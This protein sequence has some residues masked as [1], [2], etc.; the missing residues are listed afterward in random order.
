MGTTATSF[1]TR[2]SEQVYNPTMALCFLDHLQRYGETPRQLL[3]PNLAADQDKL[4]FV[5]RIV[6]G[7]QTVLDVIRSDT[8]LEINDL[9]SRFTLSKLM[10][11][12]E[13]DENV[14][15]SYLYY[16]GLLTLSG[17]TETRDLRLVPPN[18][19]VRKLFFERLVTREVVG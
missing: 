19:V 6:A 13:G 5:A 18:L 4:R 7:Q 10:D 11:L 3:D 16:I 12:L 15:V 2:A 17:E 8:P 9:T 14:V 1:S